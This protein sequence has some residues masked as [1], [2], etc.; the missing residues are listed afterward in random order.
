MI[1]S[2]YRCWCKNVYSSWW[3]CYFDCKG[4][5]L[6]DWG[7]PGSSGRF[8]K[9]IMPSTLRIMCSLQTGS[10]PLPGAH[11][12]PSLNSHCPPVE[13]FEK[14]AFD[15]HNLKNWPNSRSFTKAGGHVCFYS[16]LYA[17]CFVCFAWIFQM[18]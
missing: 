14:K 10:W 4:S 9:S 6:R 18:M 5:G 15:L 2:R 16:S 8:C 12:H 3:A 1:N 13:I 11:T 7:I 17:Q